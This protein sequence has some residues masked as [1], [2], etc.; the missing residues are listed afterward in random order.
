MAKLSALRTDLNASNDGVLTT[1]D[2]VK[3]VVAKWNN[4][5]HQKFIREFGK[6]NGTAMQSGAMSDERSDYL[7]AEHYIHIVKD[8]PELEEDDGTKIEFS[9]KLVVDLARNEQY[10]DF[11]AK[12]ERFSKNDL[13]YRVEN[14]KKLGEN[15]PTL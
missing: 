3:V 4:K 8:F 6:Q 14:V 1:I 2:G 5:E 11:F 15:L 13:N 7:F 10:L 12:I 9:Q